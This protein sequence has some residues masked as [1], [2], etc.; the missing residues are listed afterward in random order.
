MK[1]PLFPLVL[2]SITA[3]FSACGSGTD[4]GIDPITAMYDSIAKA[5][6]L[7]QWGTPTVID[8]SE[9]ND[10]SK[11]DLQRVSLEGYV[12]IADSITQTDE[13]TII[14]LWQRKGQRVGNCYSIA[15]SMGAVNNSMDSL[16]EN[17]SKTDLHLRDNSGAG[18]SLSDRVRITG[19]YH[20]PTNTTYGE[21]EVQLI[22]KLEDIPFDF[23]HSSAALLAPASSSNVKENSLVYADGYIIVPSSL[24]V[25]EFV[26][27]K[28]IATRSA[29]DTLSLNIPIG[30]EPNQIEDLPND[31]GDE[32]IKIHDNAGKIVGYDKVR[33]Y[34]IWHNGAIAT[35]YITLIR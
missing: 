2:I 25:T 10:F 22:E 35:E 3:L 15:V 21:I 28:L 13:S 30:N 29:A 32:D 6:S 4:N 7:R 9:E 11:L 23:S 1:K 18:V 14:Q 31:Y 17:Y 20:R 12:G 24:H 5:D 33:V 27:L 26:P 8:F 19:I 34:G 16:P